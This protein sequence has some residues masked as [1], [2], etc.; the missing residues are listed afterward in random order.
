MLVWGSWLGWGRGKRG[1]RWL[2]GEAR[3]AKGLGGGGG[4][5][6]AFDLNSRASYFFWSSALA[7]VRFL[8]LSS[9]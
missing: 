7:V 4:A 9:W 1:E 8:I 2:G 6:F 5:Y 3:G